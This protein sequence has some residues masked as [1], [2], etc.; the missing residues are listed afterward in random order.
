[1]ALND[2]SPLDDAEGASGGR[3]RPD[4]RGRMRLLKSRVYVGPNVYSSQPLI[5]MTLDLVGFAG[6]P[7]ADF[8]DALSAPLR[9][10][11]PGI[12][13]EVTAE[14]V[15]FGERMRSP[16]CGLGEVMARFALRLQRQAG[17]EAETPIATV[18]FGADPDLV[19][20]LFGYASSD[21]GLK[22]GDVARLSMLEWIDPDPRQPFDVAAEIA[23]LADF[24]A[25][26]ALGPSAMAL[27]RAAEARGIPWIRLNDASLI[28]LGQ[29][30]H[31][32]RIEAAL[33][34]RTS[35]IA[36]DIAKDKEFCRRLLANLGLPVP[37]QAYVRN[38]KECVRA[39][40]RIGYPVVV[41]PVDGNHGRGV[42]I[43][44]KDEA[45][46]R[47]AYDIAREESRGVIVESMIPGADHRLLVVDGRLVAAAKRMPAHVLGDGRSSI[48]KLVKTANA[49]PRRG[50]GHESMLTY[51]EID[52]AALDILTE[53]GLSPKSVPKK[54]DVVFL[55][56]TANLS[57]GGTAI[58]VTD[59]IH[60]NNK[61]M[62][63]RAI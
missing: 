24:A 42:S 41:K 12:E 60:N 52:Q 38:A 6:R 50:A 45:A 27:V 3:G 37:D 29:G 7:A 9:A 15:P 5:R 54:G 21:V 35:S 47:A 17:A 1:L 49:D 22:A 44:L 30:K 46:V 2:D 11:A 63:E 55:K 48:E 33:T 31:Q 8:G 58:D 59:I 34:S 32:N 53:L 56:R 10:A 20:V 51:I 43:D 23:D 4:P 13:Q 57:T 19:E 14:G 26:R 39:A 16:D 28:Q 62:A 61:L 25:S 40:E 36:V 18:A